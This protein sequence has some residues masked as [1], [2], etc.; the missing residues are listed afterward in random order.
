MG[1]WLFKINANEC[2]DYL[3]SR[4]RRD[5]R[6]QEAAPLPSERD[7]PAESVERGE[8]R[9]RI[10]AALQR[11]SSDEREA[12]ALKHIEGFSYQEMSELL[13]ASIPALKMRV[14]R[15]REELQTLLEDYT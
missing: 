15:A 2:K 11:L 1:A 9:A 14:H 8:I 10:E 6:L 7:D 5:L 13:N 12:F 4:R 3:K